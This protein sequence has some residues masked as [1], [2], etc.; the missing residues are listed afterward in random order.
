M[1]V[2]M[3]VMIIMMMILV[4]N[5]VIY[6]I[7]INVIWIYRGETMPILKKGS[8]NSE[9]DDD[10]SALFESRKG[11]VHLRLY[12]NVNKFLDYIYTY[13]YICYIY[14]YIDIFSN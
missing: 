13:I 14:M 5:I 8:S 3:M 12:I 7:I 1:I 11:N 2:I 9:F 10:V 6:M 4:I